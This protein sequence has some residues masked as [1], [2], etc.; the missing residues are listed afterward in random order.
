MKKYLILLLLFIGTAVAAAQ[1]TAPVRWRSTV[2][3]TSATEGVLTVKAL[4]S[5]GYHF[6]GTSLPANGPVPTTLDFKAS[7]G[8]KFI[9]EFLP[10]IKPTA[11][12]DQT[13]GMTLTWWD[14]NVTFTR[15]FKVTDKSKALI[16]GSIRYMACK[17]QSCTP[18][19]T[20]SVRI[21]VPEYKP[22]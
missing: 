7:T 3:M 1:T 2:K 8:I 4:L 10:S 11:H 18:P 17:D 15:R 5:P 12:K 22:Q 14:N 19:R 13:F 6:Y 9:G 20:E 21:V 16:K